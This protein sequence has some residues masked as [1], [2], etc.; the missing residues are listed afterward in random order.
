MRQILPRITALALCLLLLIGILPAALA[1]D[2]PPV[3]EPAENQQQTGSPEVTPWPGYSTLTLKIPVNAAGTYT[4]TELENNSYSAP[5]TRTFTFPVTEAGA[6]KNA[7]VL[8]FTEPEYHKYK[9]QRTDGDAR[10]NQEYTVEIMIVDE[11]GQLTNTPTVGG[12]EQLAMVIYP[13]MEGTPASDDKIPGIVNAAITLIKVGEGTRPDEAN[14]PLEG[15]EFELYGEDA[16]DSTVTPVQLKSDAKPLLASSSSDDAAGTS[17]NDTGN[18]SGNDAGANEDTAQSTSFIT[19]TDGKL[20]VGD[21]QP[22]V[23]YL[24]EVT[25]PTRYRLLEGLI[26]ITV[27]YQLNPTSGTLVPTVEVEATNEND[28]VSEVSADPDKTGSTRDFVFTVTDR[29]DWGNLKIVKTVAP[30]A[31]YADTA[32]T[33][34]YHITA[35]FGGEKIFEDIRSIDWPEESEVLIEDKILV[36]SVVTV[37]ETYDGSRYE[38]SGDP[39]IT[40]SGDSTGATLVITADK[41]NPATITFTNTNDGTDTEGNG[42]LNTYAFDGVNWTWQKTKGTGTDTGSSDTT[43]EGTAENSTSGGTE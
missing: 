5:T 1:D 7:I 33:F 6:E 42:I 40:Q 41:A 11:N 21:L 38:R 29:V 20:T 15:A 12:K 36:G 25:P 9:L 10:N 27:G 13:S 22:G 39:V 17:N 31:T 30:S 32:A 4:L 8:E 23:Y 34:V 16:V 19:V 37:E 28:T 2:T 43:G 26:K 14:E 35:F 3:T 18:P 24:K